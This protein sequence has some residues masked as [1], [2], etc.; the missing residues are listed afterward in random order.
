MA[1]DLRKLFEKERKE[2]RFKMKE[3][4]EGISTIL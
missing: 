2:K 4:H 3:G 1:R